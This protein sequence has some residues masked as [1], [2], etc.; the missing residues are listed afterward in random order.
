MHMHWEN[1]PMVFARV[2]QNVVKIGSGFLPSSALGTFEDPMN[3]MSSRIFMRNE[4]L[5]IAPAIT[6]TIHQ[7]HAI[8]TGSLSAVSSAVPAFPDRK[9]I[10]EDEGL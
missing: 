9:W 1:R 6:F 8:T 3:L 4:R 10:P 7:C 2:K 5:V